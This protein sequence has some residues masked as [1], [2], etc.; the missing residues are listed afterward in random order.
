MVREP[1][2]DLL[3][4]AYH[5]LCHANLKQV[6]RQLAALYSTDDVFLID[7]DHGTQPDLRPI[8]P[9][10]AKSN[11]RLKLDA[12]IGWGGAGTLRKTLNGAFELLQQD[13]RWLYYIV[14]SGQDLP[15]QSNENIK[16]R[17][18]R[19]HK[20]QINCI[21]GF[22]QPAVPVDSLPLLN[23]TDKI[24]RFGDRGHTRLFALPGSIEPQTTF[25]A[26][27]R[28]EIVELGHA[29]E[30]Y[31][32]PC[33]SLLMRRRE[34]FFERHE[35]WTGAN[36]FNLHRSLIEAMSVDPFTYELYEVLSS[37]YIPDES[38]FQTYIAN[39]P[40]RN[41][42]DKDHTRLINRP[43]PRLGVGAFS[44]DD[45]SAIQA[46]S[47]LYARKFD[48]HKDARIVDQVLENRC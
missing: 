47:A 41:R 11:V 43:A 27:W 7:V 14:L 34:M 37:T 12:N 10:L 22:H 23:K 31:V 33:T 21:R 15:L 18:Q 16:Q 9:W 35:F 24:Q 45:W 3:M 6:S 25:A 4:I 19:L 32:R 29:S 20:D 8:E 2:N 42:M 40:F 26:R 46:S 39:S 30:V 28:V 44:S 13:D 38:F 5:I 1:A 36:W 48:M 17:L